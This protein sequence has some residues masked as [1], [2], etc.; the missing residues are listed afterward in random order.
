MARDPNVPSHDVD[1]DVPITASRSSEPDPPRSR[2]VRAAVG[3]IAGL[4]PVSVTF[5]LIDLHT[6][7]ACITPATLLG[8]FAR[9]AL[10]LGLGAATVLQYPRETDLKK[11]FHLGIAYPALLGTLF[12]S[13]AAAQ[14]FQEPDWRRMRPSAMVSV[15]L[16]STAAER[17]ASDPKGDT[18]LGRGLFGPVRISEA[19]TEFR[20][21]L[22][23]VVALSLVSLFAGIG[24]AVAVNQTPAIERLIESCSTTWKLGFG[25]IVGLIGGKAL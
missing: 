6:T 10:F 23:C 20:L 17:V 12:A 15:G 3:G 13:L 2:V 8:Y 4:V 1:V 11:V 24:L 22:G 5:V 16:L 7:F 18:G 19:S 25:A 21:I 9:V 14:T